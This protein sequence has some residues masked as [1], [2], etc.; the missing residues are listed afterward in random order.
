[1][2][3]W[4][5]DGRG[6]LIKGHSRSPGYRLAIQGISV[7]FTLIGYGGTAAVLQYGKFASQLSLLV[8]YFAHQFHK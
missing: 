6:G 2:L 4:M 8:Q 1:M 3:M 7:E 5:V